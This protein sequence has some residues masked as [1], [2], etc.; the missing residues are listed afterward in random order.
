MNLQNV[1]QITLYAYVN[2]SICVVNGTIF[3]VYLFNTIIRMFDKWDSH[4]VDDYYQFKKQ[5][6][7]RNQNLRKLD[8]QR[9]S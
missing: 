6:L 7:C 2:T 1:L 8:T 3:V 9:M 5:Y 4:L